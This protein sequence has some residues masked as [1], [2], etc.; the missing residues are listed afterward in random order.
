[1]P[2]DEESQQLDRP[3]EILD[4]AQDSL[5]FDRTRQFGHD[6]AG[7]PGAAPVRRQTMPPATA[8]DMISE[9]GPKR[10]KMPVEPFPDGAPEMMN[11]ADIVSFLASHGVEP[12]G[13]WHPGEPIL[14][15]IEDAY[16]TD[17]AHY[18]EL[19]NRLRPSIARL[20]NPDSI[21]SRDRAVDKNGRWT[22][23]FRIVNET[24]GQV[25]YYAID[26]VTHAVTFIKSSLSIRDKGYPYVAPGT[27]LF[28]AKD[29]LFPK[30]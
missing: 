19:P 4:A 12:L 5:G 22:E 3:A 7:A 30:A 9:D 17:T 25:D 18:G 27:F 10:Q 2:T 24:G 21:D 6:D 26:P 16:R 29:E 14:Y 13:E 28:C 11:Q 23:I 20:D 1:M 15:V 8:S